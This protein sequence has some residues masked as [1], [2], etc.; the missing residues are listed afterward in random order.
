[1]MKKI[2]I[3]FTILFFTVLSNP[4]LA[5]SKIVFD[6]LVHDF[7]DIKEEDGDAQTIFD[8]TNQGNKPLKL[9]SVKASCGCTTP[10]WSSEEVAVKGMGY[11]QVSYSTK[12]RPGPFTKTI[13]VRT[14][15]NPQVLVLTIKGNVIPRPKGPKDWYPM[16][17][18]NLRFK[19]THILIGN[20]LNTGKDTVSTVIYNQGVSPVNIKYGEVKVPEYIKVWGTKD[21]LT[22][23]DTATVFISYDAS[24]K[25]DYGYLF[26]YFQLP[27][28]D[29]D[30]PKKRINVSA[31]I[32]EDFSGLAEDGSSPA[33]EFDKVTQQLGEMKAL[34][35][36]SAA[37]TISNT[38]TS[39]LILRKVKASCGCTATKPQ[40]TTLAPG[41]ST[42]LDVTFTA[43]NY[44]RQ[45]KKS[46]TIITN[47]P[48]KPE[49]TL[50]IEADVKSTEG[51]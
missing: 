25:E 41:E 9:T 51:N 24:M 43:G 15:G 13:S 1:M 11:V 33:V 6:S 49:T 31:H 26:E 19:T 38:G 8:F 18:G 30:S 2:Y 20:I 21:K 10:N 14:N 16:E 29:L 7:G 12:N 4:L 23:K 34:D 17:I 45:V 47:D 28:S 32:K 27:T 37:F 46:I 40:K 42:K 39:E 48:K 22:A 44:T 36:K 35:K 3:S 50:Y 5:Q